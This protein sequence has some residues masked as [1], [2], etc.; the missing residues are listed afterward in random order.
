MY[1]KSSNHNKFAI[2]V[3]CRLAAMQSDSLDVCVCACNAILS[4]E[5]RLACRHL[6]KHLLFW[7]IKI[8]FYLPKMPFH[9]RFYFALIYIK[10]L[11]NLT[12]KSLRYIAR[13]VPVA[14]LQF[15][16]SRIT[17]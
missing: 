17:F 3:S 2:H 15:L 16:A 13:C 10:T 9:T 4:G 1:D 8:A 5:I 6:H 14:F 7:R 11:S 12:S